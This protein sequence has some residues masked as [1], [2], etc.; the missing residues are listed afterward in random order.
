M[1]P[2]E[3][4]LAWLGEIWERGL[5]DGEKTPGAAKTWKAFF[6]VLEKYFLVSIGSTQALSAL[7]FKEW[8]KEAGWPPAS[9]VTPAAAIELAASGDPSL[10]AIPAPTRR[11]M[12][13]Y[14]LRHSASME[15]LFLA[16]GVREAAPVPP[17]E[18]DKP[19][20]WDEMEKRI[21]ER[22]RNKARRLFGLFPRAVVALS[23]AVL[24]I[25]QG[26]ARHPVALLASTGVLVVG[27]GAGVMIAQRNGL[28]PA[29]TTP[30]VDFHFAL[31]KGLT[32]QIE[33][34]GTVEIGQAGGLERR[35]ER[36]LVSLSVTNRNDRW[37]GLAGVFRVIQVAEGT[38]APTLDQEYKSAFR[39]DDRGQMDIPPGAPQPSVRSIPSFPATPVRL[40]DSWSMPCE[41]WY[42]D[43]KPPFRIQAQAEYTWLSNAGAGKEELAVIRVVYGARQ[44]VPGREAIAALHLSNRGTL[45]W[46]AREGLPVRYEER[47]DEL[48]FMADGKKIAFGMAFT[49]TYTVARS[50]AR[51]EQDAV[52][53]DF[54]AAISK[55]R[56][57]EAFID[58]EGV[59]VRLGDILFAH[60]SAVLAPESLRVLDSLR[61]VLARYPGYDIRVSGH[62]DS[63]GAAGYNERLSLDRAKSVTEYLA[64]GGTLPRLFA[65]GFGASRPVGD[66]RSEEGR[67]KN[68]R[69]EITLRQ[70]GS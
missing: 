28:S 13:R 29:Q 44:V 54:Q 18:E 35:S 64:K 53:R 32:I 2:L 66:N 67:R 68:R 1:N 37:A 10:L 65:Q 43:V 27:I 6:A 16:V 15:S 49:S 5:F 23:A 63:T 11:A 48:W 31:E 47:H 33:K 46:N 17:S 56:E 14:L 39:M 40:G 22:K 58:A 38:A 20:S 19:P 51:K 42:Y 30:A 62:A 24:L 8:E 12:G 57:A 52:R 25:R 9:P 21:R 55:T 41:I 69:V 59:T 45:W 50:M 34:L 36:N 4:T 60:N 61:P 7:M 3:K 70:P 26:F